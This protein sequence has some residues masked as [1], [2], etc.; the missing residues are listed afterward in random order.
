[1][2]VQPID[3]QVLFARLNLIG[4]EQIAHRSMIVQAQAVAAE[5]I[6][7]RSAEEDRRVGGLQTGEEGPEQV[8]DDSESRQGSQE[9]S[10]DRE[11]EREST[12]QE[13][14][15]DPDLGQNIDISG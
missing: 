4:R 14:L 5:E 12:N 11:P 1:M 3:L 2:S 9:Q 13:V 15:R 10:R 6:A 8:S 7:E